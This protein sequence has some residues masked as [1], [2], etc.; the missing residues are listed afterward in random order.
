MDFLGKLKNNTK[1]SLVIYYNSALLEL[2][3]EDV[4]SVVADVCMLAVFTAINISEIYIYIDINKRQS[5][6]ILY[7]NGLYEE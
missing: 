1:A 2:P 7:C 3:L 4:L 5:N 6:N